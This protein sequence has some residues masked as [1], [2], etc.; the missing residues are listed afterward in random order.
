VKWAAI[1]G[2]AALV[3]GCGRNDDTMAQ[4]EKPVAT[5]GVAAPSIGETK[6]IAEEGFIL[7]LPIVM[8]YAATMN[9]FASAEQNGK[10]ADL[11]QELEALFER[12][13]RSEA[14]DASSIPATFLRVTVA[15]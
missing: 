10:A 8:N 5:T 4:A 15:L 13:N 1:I 7:G 11:Q 6:A 9:A 12:Q 14:K 3:T 2:A